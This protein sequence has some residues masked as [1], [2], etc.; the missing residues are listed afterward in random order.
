MKKTI[1]ILSVLAIIFLNNCSTK[2]TNKAGASSQT[3]TGTG[4]GTF[5]NEWTGVRLANKDGAIACESGDYDSTFDGVRNFTIECSNGVRSKNIFW[6]QPPYNDLS[7]GETTYYSNKV[8]R[9]TKSYGFY[10]VGNRETRYK[11]YEATYRNDGTQI[12]TIHFHSN[13][14]ESIK[15]S[16][17]NDGTKISDIYFYS[18]GQE[19]FKNLYRNNG[20][21]RKYQIFDMNGGVTG[22]IYYNTSNNVACDPQSVKCVTTDSD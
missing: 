7:Q 16:Y 14:Q 20:T 8:I 3:G 12:A 4:T 1:L 6:S 2:N 17:R 13:G 19:Y 11:S 10:E 21:K 9:D 15:N 18:N 22:T 5:T